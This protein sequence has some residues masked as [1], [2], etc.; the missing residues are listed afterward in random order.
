[1]LKKAAFIAENAASG[2]RHR[3]TVPHEHTVPTRNTRALPMQRSFRWLFRSGSSTG[4]RR[5]GSEVG[6][7][8]GG[9][10][11]VE[12]AQMQNQPPPAAKRGRSTGAGS[13]RSLTRLLRQRRQTKSDQEGIAY[14]ATTQVGAARAAAKPDVS[15]IGMGDAVQTTR[16]RN[17][18][19]ASRLWRAV[20]VNRLAGRGV[21][22]R[23]SLTPEA[24]G[25]TPE[26]PTA[27]RIRRQSDNWMTFRSRDGGIRR[28][29][30]LPPG[31]PPLPPDSSTEE[32]A[33]R[34]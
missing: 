13:R 25:A 2:C 30:K 22:E 5:G 11:S 4:S 18:V 6:A 9:P 21:R 19:V 7:A 10:L 8:V 12:S 3:Q 28:V 34:L 29:R 33:G 27:S 1:M 23:P 14:T 32:G 16:K 26:D 17:T 31:L 20:H 24:A 15:M